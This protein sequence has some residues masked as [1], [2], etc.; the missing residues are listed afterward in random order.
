MKI[1]T[2]TLILLLGGSSVH[3]EDA[4]DPFAETNPLRSPHVAPDQSAPPKVTTKFTCISSGTLEGEALDDRVKSIVIAIS[5]FH[6]AHKRVPKGISELIAF[7]K[8]RGFELYDLSRLSPVELAD[9]VFKYSAGYQSGTLH[10]SHI[11][12]YYFTSDMLESKTAE[13][14]PRE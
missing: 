8:K 7:G 10:L 5:D 3:S 13:S 2:T 12:G 9:G 14:G 1:P 11:S 6:E 4:V